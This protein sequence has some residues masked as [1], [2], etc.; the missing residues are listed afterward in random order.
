MPSRRTFVGIASAA[1]LAACSR[2][3]TGSG[4]TI[5][6]LNVSY[7]PTRELYAEIN[8][9]FSAFWAAQPGRGPVNITMS[10]GGSG[11][12]TRSV[13][14]GAPA[15]VVT[16]ATPND[17][18]QIAERGLTNRN[19]RARLPNNSAPY[20]SIIVFVVHQGN[21]KQIRD[22]GD[23]IRPDVRIVTPDPKTSGG[24]RWTYLAAWAF[25]ERRMQMD[26]REFLRRLYANAGTLESGARAATSR[27][28]QGEGDVLI[29]WE[30]EAHNLLNQGGFQIVT[31]S[32]SIR[33]EPAVAVVD[34][35]TRDPEVRAAAEGYLQFLYTLQAQ[36]IIARQY[37]RPFDADVLRR[38]AS[39]FPSVPLVTVE[40]V[41]QSW[42]DAYET[43]FR[44]GGVFDQIR[45][46][47][48]APATQPT[49]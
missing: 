19:W 39:R 31:P 17:I 15:Q 33:A 21:P 38:N 11:A 8:P 13:I 43:H 42:D 7:D 26:T 45:S 41:F 30:N 12:Q 5:E 44:D 1:L 6:L 25:G 40:A 34:A 9:L 10:H 14:E 20:T 22:W 2:Q 49:P 24:A 46:T 16:L 18:D 32:L 3:S 23:L 28:Y 29:A 4:D 36:E 47:I 27:F 48:E 35:N 37:Y